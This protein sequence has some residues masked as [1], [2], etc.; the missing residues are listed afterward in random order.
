VL[1]R[2]GGFG[3]VALSLFPDPATGR[4]KDASWQVLGEEL[5]ALLS[6]EEYASARRTTFN[7]FYTS[8]AVIAAIHYA[9]RRLGVPTNA[10]VLE[11][12]CGTG[13]FMAAA[14][15]G[16]RFIGV[17]LDDISGRIARALYPDHD[18]RI[19]DFRES[20]LPENHIDAVIGNPPFADVRLDFHGLRLPLHDY[21]LA[22]SLNALKPGGILALVTSRFTLDKLCSPPHNKSCV[23]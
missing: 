18:I 2:F 6:P 11:P 4:Y 8:P 23:A 3:A 5:Q 15:S 16:M 10:T 19:E 13:N 22:K 9:I 12:G 1:S 7:A 20:R 14:P 21:F 17:E